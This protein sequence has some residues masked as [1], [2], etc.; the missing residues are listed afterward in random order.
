MS[1]PTRAV[2]RYDG[3][4]TIDEL[5]RYSQVMADGTSVLPKQ[6]RQQP[7]AILFAVEYAKALD[8]SPV[9]AIT[10]MHVIDGKPTASAGLISA[11]IR[12]AG[13][14]LRVKLTGTYEAGDLKAV[15]TIVRSDDPD[16]T[17]ESVWTLERAERALLVKRRPDRPGYMAVKSGSAWDT[18]P[19]SMLKARALTEVARDAAEDVLLGVHYTPEELGADVDGSGDPVRVQSERVDEP[20]QP[21]PSP[22]RQEPTPDPAPQAP[23]QESPADTA[24]L[25]AVRDALLHAAT[26]KELEAVWH[27]PVIASSNSTARNTRTADADGVECTLYELFAAAVAAV[28]AGGTLAGDGIEDAV[29]VPDPSEVAVERVLNGLDP[30]DRQTVLSYAEQ[31]KLDGTTTEGRF[32]LL[33]A[34]RQGHALPVAFPVDPGMFLEEVLSPPIVTTL[35]MQTLTEDTLRTLLEALPPA[36]PPTEPERYTPGAQRARDAARGTQ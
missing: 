20:S 9:T 24:T 11:L 12:R 30:G 14:K 1:E 13:H 8:V 34:I 26:L 32:A 31:E 33:E 19:E 27:G 18:Y 28:K 5:V 10:G 3:P 29:I 15:A 21:A 7:G 17:Y 22:P 6:F 25:E 23:V 35:A 16:E 36:E 2:A 4:R